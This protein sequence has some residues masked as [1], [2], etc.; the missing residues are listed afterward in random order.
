VAV[1]AGFAA[2]V[3]ERFAG[4]LRAVSEGDFPLPRGTFGMS[5]SL[6]RVAGDANAGGAR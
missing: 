2:P 5:S 3:P 4:G 1:A 6:E